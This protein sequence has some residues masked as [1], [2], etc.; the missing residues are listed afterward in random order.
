MFELKFTYVLTKHEEKRV[1]LSNMCVP[2]YK[3]LSDWQIFV[4]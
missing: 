1:F 3:Q 4:M 2:L